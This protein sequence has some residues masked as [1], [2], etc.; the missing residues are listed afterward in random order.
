MA[1]RVGCD[2]GSSRRRRDRQLRAWH[3]HVLLTVAMELATTLR[4]S[5]QPAGLVVGGPREE[6]VHETHYGLRA[7]KR[8]SPGT[9]PAPLAEVAGPLEVAATAGYV[10]AV[11]APLLV[12]PALRGGDAIDDTSVHFLLEMALKTPEQV[13][14]LRT[15][16]RR[17][18][19]REREEGEQ[20]KK[21]WEQGKNQQWRLRGR[22]RR[23]RR[24]CPRLP[25]LF[26]PLPAA[27]GDLDAFPR[28]HV[29]G[30][31]CSVSRC[32]LRSAGC[33]DSS[34]R[35]RLLRNAWFNCGYCSYV[36]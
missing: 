33:S 12:V 25:P 35:G 4:H 34:G 3:R 23:G 5:A 36:S 1:E 7:K 22:G 30:S 9:R 10:A 19:A 24:S 16:E 27:L 32:C 29:S 18:L 8:P 15:A 26:L 31:L 20:E 13:E 2:G 11:C 17:K 28:A 14:R 6:E 21:K